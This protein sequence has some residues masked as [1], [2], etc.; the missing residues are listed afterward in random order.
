[1]SFIICI[2]QS[3]GLLRSVRLFDMDV[4]GPPTLEDGTDR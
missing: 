3:S 1:M 2:L 4:S